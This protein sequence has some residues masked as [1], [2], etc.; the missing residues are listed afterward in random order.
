MYLLFAW[1]EFPAGGFHDYIRKF[2]DDEAALEY[3]DRLFEGWDWQIIDANAGFE[4]LYE[5]VSL[6]TPTSNTENQEAPH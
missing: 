5:S 4:I 1:R 6:E 3:V 2:D